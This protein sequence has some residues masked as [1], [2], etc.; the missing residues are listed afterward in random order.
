MI[1]IIYYENKYLILSRIINVPEVISYEYFKFTLVRNPW[2]RFVS[3]FNYFA[4]GERG[5]GFDLNSQQI[6][7]R[8]KS[9]SDFAL[10]FDNVKHEFRAPCFLPQK[11]CT[12]DKNSEPLLDFIGR[13]V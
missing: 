3:V 2:D 5:L 7:L 1:W 13:G 12:H 8:Y 4:T 6:I 11:S 9:F 10:G